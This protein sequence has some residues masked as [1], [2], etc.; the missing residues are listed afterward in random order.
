VGLG[1]YPL[2]LGFNSLKAFDQ[3]WSEYFGGQKIYPLLKYGA[4]IGQ[5]AQNNNLKVYLLMF[6][7]WVIFLI[8]IILV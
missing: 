7:F 4:V 1:L 3:G 6:I 5:F 8:V 2:V